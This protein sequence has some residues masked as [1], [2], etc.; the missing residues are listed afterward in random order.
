[1]KVFS[2]GIKSSFHIKTVSNKNND[3]S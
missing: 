2:D 3:S 1:M